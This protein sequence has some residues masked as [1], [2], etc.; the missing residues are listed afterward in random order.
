M[1]R[2]IYEILNHSRSDDRV[3]HFVGSALLLLTAANVIAS[4]LETDARIRN[5][6]PAFFDGFE[7]VSVAIFTIEYVLRLWS[8]TA[9][10]HF[11]GAVRGRVRMA[12]TPL[13][14]I[15]LAAIA[16]SYLELL[17]P[18]ALDLRFVRVLRLLRLFRLLRYSRI[19]DA[20]ATLVRVL[21]SKHVDLA[22]SLAIVLVAMLLAAGMAYV[23]ERNAPG[24]EFTSIPRAM[25][26]SVVTITTIGYGDMVPL[27]PAGRVIGGVIA[28]I[29]VCAVA[30]PVGIVSSG[31]IEELNRRKRQPTAAPEEGRRCPH[32]GGALDG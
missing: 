18:G 2:R 24:T 29:G 23:A 3:G 32:C 19:A 21:R 10:P 22:V 27:T 9:D 11:A 1:R 28:F 31:F 30:L 20:F 8:C 12:L 26:W 25:W 7:V 13:A 5:S 16:P 6:A 17:L 15:D 4:I 14:L